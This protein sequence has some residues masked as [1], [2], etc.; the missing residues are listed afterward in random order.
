MN[1]DMLVGSDDVE[2]IERTLRQIMTDD[3]QRR[4]QAE[5]ARIEALAHYCKVIWAERIRKFTVMP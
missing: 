3:R 4:L 2:D 1:G 5:Q